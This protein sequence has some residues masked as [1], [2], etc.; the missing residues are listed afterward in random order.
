MIRFVLFTMLLLMLAACGPKQFNEKQYREEVESWHRKR[1]ENLKKA[2][3][4][5]TLEGLFWLESG[6]NSFG[7]AAGNALVFPEGMPDR[8]GRFVL[9]DTVVTVHIEHGVEVT[10]ADTLLREGELRADVTGEPT[11]LKWKSYSWYVI[12]R[13]EKYGIRLKNSASPVLAGFTGIERF[14]VDIKWRVPARLVPHEDKTT[15]PVPNVLGQIVN[16]PSPGSLLFT[17]EGREYR[18]DPVATAGDEEYFIVFADASNGETTYGAGRFLTVPRVNEEG[19]T[20]IDFNRAY[21]PPCVFTPYATCPL[22]PA[23]NRLD[24]SVTA[25][26]KVWGH[27]E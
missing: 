26:E 8:M 20:W 24:I 2:D 13:Q 16:E 5:L 14:P 1:I 25:G 7:A 18:L 15:I 4:W 27:H 3:G 10:S 9:N 19:M 21:N 23:Q 22:P 12:K 11:I 17:I 6:E